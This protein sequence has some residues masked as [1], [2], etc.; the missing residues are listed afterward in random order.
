MPRPSLKEERRAAILEAYGRCIAQHGVEG[1]TLEMT[2]DEAGLARALIRHNVGNK[3]DLLDAYVDQFL[4]GSSAEADEL[5]D[6]LP[7]NR[8]IETMIEWLFDPQYANPQNVSASNALFTAATTDKKLAKRLHGWTSDFTDRIRQELV[9]SR[10]KAGSKV[11]AVATG[12]VAIYYNYETL[13]PL[14][15][16]GDLRRNS[17]AAAILLASTLV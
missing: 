4:A 3:D 13:A 12:I 8:R 14:G 16:A 5:F 1:A 10:P 11:D 9:A 7:V 17:E 6:S 2:A 15:D